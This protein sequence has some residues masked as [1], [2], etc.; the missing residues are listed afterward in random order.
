MVGIFIYIHRAK[1]AE[2]LMAPQDENNEARAQ[3]RKFI[4][5]DNFNSPDGLDD[6]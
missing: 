1:I 2:F 6:T 4:N 5:I 3:R